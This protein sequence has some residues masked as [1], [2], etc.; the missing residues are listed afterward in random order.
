MRRSAS[1]GLLGL[2][3]VLA[4]GTARAHEVGG[5]RFDAPIP[6]SL[7]FVGA[8]AT[9]A[10]TAGWLAASTPSTATTA[11]RRRTVR[12]PATAAAAGETLSRG[13]FFLA[14]L[15]AI[16]AGFAGPQVPAENVA[17]VF[18]WPVW[19]KGVAL[20]AA[21][22]GDP[23][24]V[25]SPWRTVYD[26]LVRLE[27]ADVAV[28]GSYPE[29]LGEWP[30]LVGFVLWIG[31][32]ENLTVIPRSP[33][34]TAFLLVGYAT[35]MLAG[36]VA[37]GPEWFERADAFAVLYRLFGRVAPVRLDRTQTGEY[38]ASLRPP[39]R[40]CT[41]AVRSLAVVSFVV[42]TVYTVS[43]DGFTSTPEYQ[44]VL[45]ALRD[46]TGIGPQVSVAAYLAGFLLWIGVFLAIVVAAERAGTGREWRR[47]ARVLAPTLLPIAVAYE[48]AHNY[49]F[50]LRSLGQLV[51]V[52][53]AYAV[54]DP[55]AVAALAWLSLPAFWGSQVALIV[56]GHVVAVV[57]AHAVTVDRYPTRRRA[58]R[59]HVTLTA[60]MVAYT[61]LSLWIVSRPVA[62]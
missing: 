24:R 1:A 57:A 29:R 39:W 43:F 7:L 30:A 4:A 28:V 22:L 49:P 34:T 11:G 47:A 45:F 17:T 9:V 38:V 62:T 44:S 15:V 42:A 41:M 54:P 31:V 32:L 6:L 14:F 12:L 55:P 35:V 46:V 5:S 13:A 26:G 50:V 10:L 52:L 33:R 53:G 25:L 23:W 61:V 56:V 16:W 18:V 36:A 48:I 2:A 60:L 51:T 19:F 3:L 27:G 8:G 59:A 40:A 21:L 37:F 58:T 20:V